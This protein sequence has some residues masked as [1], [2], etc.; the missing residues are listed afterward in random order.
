MA[1]PMTPERIAYLRRCLNYFTVPLWWPKPDFETVPYRGEIPE[2]GSV[3]WGILAYEIAT[4]CT[5]ALAALA[6]AVEGD[7]R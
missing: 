4:G 3:E 6:S 1:E 2:R 5:E 7:G